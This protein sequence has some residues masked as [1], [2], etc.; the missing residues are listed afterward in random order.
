MS[1]FKTSNVKITG[2]SSVYGSENLSIDQMECIKNDKDKIANLKSKIGL[3]K[4]FKAT[5]GITAFDLCLLAIKKIK[6][7]TNLIDENV[8]TIIFVTQT[9]DYFL[10]SN[11]AL[12]HKYLKLDT[13][14]ACFDI[15]QGCAGYVYGLW[16]SNIILNNS[17]KGSK[18]LLLAGDTMTHALDPSDQATMPIFGDAGT[19]TV[20]E[21]MGTDE[22]NLESYF[23]LNM[24]G[25]GSESIIIKN[26]GFR[27]ISKKKKERVTLKMEGLKV[28]N[29]ALKYVPI[30]INN[31][32]NYSQIP[33][34]DIDHIILH[35]A[36]DF[37]INNLIKKMKWVSN[38]V[39]RGIVGRYGNH[40]PASIPFTISYS[41]GDVKIKN[42]KNLL[43]CGFGTGFSFASSIIKLS[44]IYCPKPIM[45][46][47]Y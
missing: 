13:S 30:S 27:E 26:G 18:I 12:I 15:N 10:P 29:Y 5:S 43:L 31:I 39:P 32:L 1:L 11:A 41:L 16:L 42:S 40:G 3:N 25:Q 33:I 36:N 34:D 20:L 37:V 47:N 2:L 14:C 21:N 46:Q 38:K 8:K 7:E 4:V 45:Y 35:Q 24:D 28:Y 6:D 9:P 19:A 17:T 44:S 22:Q 23:D